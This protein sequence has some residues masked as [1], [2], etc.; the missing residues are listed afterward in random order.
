[1]TKKEAADFLNVSPRTIEG[2]AAKGKLTRATA[3]GKRGDITVYDES[4]LEK[5][6]A[7][8]AQIIYAVGP[9]TEAHAPDE[10]RSLVRLSSARGLESLRDL[11]ALVARIKNAPQVNLEGKIMLTLDDAAALSSLSVHHLREAIKAGR[12]KGKVIGRGYRIKR[13]DLDS[14]VKKL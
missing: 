4:E 10:H 8:R 12:L 3:K 13:I 7:E 6:K 9:D 5:L 1:M 2:L 11:S 14:Y